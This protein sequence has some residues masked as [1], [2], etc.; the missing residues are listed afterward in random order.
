MLITYSRVTQSLAMSHIVCKPRSLRLDGR[1][2]CLPCRNHN[3]PPKGSKDRRL[4]ES[5]FKFFKILHRIFIAFHRIIELF[6]QQIGQNL[7]GGICLD[8]KT[9]FLYCLQSLLWPPGPEL[10]P[11]QWFLPI[12][13][14]CKIEAMIVGGLASLLVVSL[15]Y[16][17]LK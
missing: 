8:C 16:L 14:F 10:G 15:S 2:S 12:A 4:N 13:R 6:S 3:V 5:Y 7:P 17:L 11:M 1:A 9:C